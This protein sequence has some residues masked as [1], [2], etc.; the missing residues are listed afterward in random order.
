[1]KIE[2]FCCEAEPLCFEAKPLC[3]EAKP[4]CFEAKPLCFEAKRLV[5]CLNWLKGFIF[6]SFWFFFIRWVSSVSISMTNNNPILL[7]SRCSA[8]HISKAVAA[9]NLS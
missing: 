7:H 4:L 5:L 9:F 2:N 6:G 8:F 1:M 3:F